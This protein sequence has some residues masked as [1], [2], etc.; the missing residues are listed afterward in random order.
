MKKQTKRHHFVPQFY[1]RYFSIDGGHQI[2]V[3][4]WNL[5]SPFKTNIT[6]CSVIQFYYSIEYEDGRKVDTIEKYFSELEGRASKIFEF[7]SDG[8]YSLNEEEMETL[9]VFVAF[10]MFRNPQFR[11]TVHDMKRRSAE[12]IMSMLSSDKNLME[13]ELKRFEKESGKPVDVDIDEVM[14]FGRDPNR[15][16]IEV[17][18]NESLEIMFTM[19]E[20]IYPKLAEM[21]WFFAKGVGTKKFVTSDLP[22]G[23][24]N[25]KIPVGS[26]VGIGMKYTEIYFPMNKDICLVGSWINDVENGKTAMMPE[27]SVDLINRIVALGAERSF[28]NSSIDQLLFE[29]FVRSKKGDSTTENK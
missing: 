2:Y 29:E 4:D 16:K 15:Y 1:L 8:R 6:N 19:V 25:S 12:A 3:H 5:S 24:H 22:I 9:L 27:S 13:S 23:M 26:P 17:H 20:R 11:D 28:Y 10:L 18:P 7:V 14:A 21:N